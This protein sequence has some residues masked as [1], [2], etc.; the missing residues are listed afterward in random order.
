MINF[1]KLLLSEAQIDRLHEQTLTILAEKGI[2]IHHE[3][4]VNIFKSHGFKTEGDVI[5]FTEKQIDTALSLCPK[6]FIWE[7]GEK[8]IIIDRDIASHFGSSAGP[9]FVLKNGVAQIGTLSDYINIAKLVETS[10]VM[11]FVHLLLTDTDDVDVN[12]RPYVQLAALLKYTSKPINITSIQTPQESAREVAV[13]Q[14]R[15]IKDFF[16]KKDKNIAVGGACPTSPL[17]Y[18]TTD[19][20]VLLGYLAEKQPVMIMTC[21][22]PAMTSPASVAATIIQNNA[23]L[24]AGIVLTQLVE[25]GTPIIYANTSTSTNLRNMG[26]SLGSSE[27]ALISVGT[28]ALAKRYKMPFRTGG[29]LSDAIDVD[30]QAGVESA[31]CASTAIYCD[32]DMMQFSCGLLGSFNLSSLE[33]Y[34]LDEQN[35]KMALRMKQGFDF[36]VDQSYIDPILKMEHRGNYLYGGMP[37][38]Y[39]R[40]HFIADIFNKEDYNSWLAKK[41][42]SVYD[43][44]TDKVT[45]RL[46]SY[47]ERDLTQAQKELLAKYLP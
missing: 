41:G 11:D 18:T 30:Y 42:K 21:S 34:V 25:P 32:V 29:C 14:I 4:A 39:R 2:L 31:Y 26:L 16:G 24:L 44:A 1:E 37:K 35:I 36:E 46:E 33:K 28:A 9:P 20:D 45:A 3:E 40:E 5:F 43:K 12:E 8:E 22:M 38:E 10:S 17:A 23:E 13:K 47:Q 7:S 27:T 15:M 6:S 19:I